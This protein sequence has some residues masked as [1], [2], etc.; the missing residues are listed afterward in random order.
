MKNFRCILLLIVALLPA[1]QFVNEGLNQLSPTRRLAQ[2]EA[3]IRDAENDYWR[4]RP[5]GIAAM[6]SVDVGDYGKAKHYA[7]ELIRLSVELFSKEKPDDDSTHK[8]NT[9]LGR[10]AL[11]DGNIAEAK[12]YLLKSAMVEGSPVLGSFGPNMTL[13]KEL[14]ENNEREVVLSI[15]ICAPNSGNPIETTR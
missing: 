7:D 11:R 2:A 13:A 8:G 3:E 4:L 5:L 12:S 6:A 1:C 14:L 9:V 15:S 10:L